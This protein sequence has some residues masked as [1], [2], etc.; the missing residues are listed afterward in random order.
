MTPEQDK[1]LKIYIANFIINDL[2]ALMKKYK[3]KIETFPL[4]A[5]VIRFL[6]K[7]VIL[8]HWDKKYVKTTVEKWAVEN[9]QEKDEKEIQH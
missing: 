5:S 9:Q 6:C 3:W 7:G 8:G 2:L 4:D 1:E